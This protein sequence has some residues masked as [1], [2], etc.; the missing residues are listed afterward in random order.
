MNLLK[1]LKGIGDK[2]GILET[3]TTSGRAPAAR[4]R[5]RTV[6]LRELTVEIKSVEVKALA[7]A[8][9]ELAIPLDKIFETA[10]IEAG[11]GSWTVDKLRQFVE[12]GNLRDKPQD[13]MQKSVLEKL[14]A[15]GVKAEELVKDA[16]ARDRALDAYETVAAKRMKDRQ[17]ICQKRIVEI[18]AE[19]GKLQQECDG[20]KGKLAADERKWNEWRQQKKAWEKEIASV[21]ACLVD[22]PVITTDD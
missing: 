22:R 20:L 17:A 6:T 5:T 3:V 8:P 7:E 13:E 11:P 12:G 15:E 18:E 4:I 2:I 1:R 14:G 10:G 9:A 19:I 16:V 21:V